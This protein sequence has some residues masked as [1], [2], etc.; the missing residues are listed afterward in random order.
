MFHLGAGGDDSGVLDAGINCLVCNGVGFFQ[1]ICKQDV[2]V[3]YYE[4]YKKGCGLHDSFDRGS[5]LC[6]F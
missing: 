3:V 5:R 4:K 1:M 6:R 2:S